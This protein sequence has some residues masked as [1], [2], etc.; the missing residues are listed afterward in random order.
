MAR[1]TGFPAIRNAF[2]LLLAVLFHCF[3]P[4]S[5]DAVVVG[6]GLAGLT[7]AQ[8]LPAGGKTVMVLEA[9]DRIGGK[10]HN[11]KL[12]NGGVYEVRAESVGPTQD[13]V[14]QMISD[15]G[16]KTFNTY[17]GGESVLWRNDTR[18]VYA[19]DPALGRSLPVAPE[20]LLQIAGAQELLN[21]WTAEIDVNTPWNDSSAAKWDKMSFQDFITANAPHPDA[22]LVLTSA[23]KDIFAAEP[24]E[25]SLL[26]VIAY[27]ASGGNE[28]TKGTLASV[29]AVQNGAQES[30][31]VSGTGLIP[32]RLAGKVGAS[33]SL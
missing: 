12:K 9:R 7:T 18:L 29:V 13:K 15:L 11:A 20:A 8:D 28:T 22:Q 5:V 4:G 26:Y 24:R 2:T 3:C 32:E 30:R 33:T 23:C 27:I 31:V 17:N 14:L 1:I 6:A 16:L 10:V 21:N 25:L 19:P